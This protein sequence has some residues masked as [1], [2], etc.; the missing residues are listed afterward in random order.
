[1]KRWTVSVVLSLAI[2]GA[3]QAAIDPREFA[4]DP[5]RQR[6]QHL[7]AVLRCPKCQ[8]QNIAESNSPIAADLRGEIRRMLTEGHSDQ[9]IVDFMV[10]RYGEFVLYDPPLST[11]T[12]LLWFGPAALLLAAGVAVVVIVA[13]R[14][15]TPSRTASALSDVERHRLARLLRDAGP[16]AEDAS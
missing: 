6:Y 12:A 3:S 8:N 13:G 5:L 11:H 10:A 9:H 4:D 16:S 2:L 14:R 1:M 7:A 15:R